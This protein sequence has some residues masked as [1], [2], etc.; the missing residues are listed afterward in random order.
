MGREG[1]I[2]KAEYPTW[3][4]KLIADD[5]IE[6][7]EDFIRKVIED[8]QEIISV[9]NLAEAKEAY[10]YTSDDWKYKALQLAAGKNMGDAMKAVMADL[11][12]RKQGKEVS[13]YIQKIISER[14]VPTA[15]TSPPYS[16][17]QKSSSPPR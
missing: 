16:T 10:I 5:T 2:A 1:F 13:R 6:K 15:S 3:D 11:E 4:E 14:L 7:S 12:M 9:A 17:R 8:A